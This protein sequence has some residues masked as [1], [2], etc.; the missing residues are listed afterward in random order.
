MQVTQLDMPSAGFAAVGGDF[1]AFVGGT[2]W[3]QRTPCLTVGRISGGS[4]AGTDDSGSEHGGISAGG[5]REAPWQRGLEDV[6]T[7]FYER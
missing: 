2:G 5:G 3:K 6:R 1:L 7:G 4:T